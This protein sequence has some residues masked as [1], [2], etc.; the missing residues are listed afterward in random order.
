[1]KLGEPRQLD[2]ILVLN[3]ERETTKQPKSIHI[4][5]LNN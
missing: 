4:V 2:H 3:W 5:P 1:M